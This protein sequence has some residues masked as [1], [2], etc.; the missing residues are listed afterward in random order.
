MLLVP[1]QLRRSGMGVP[2]SHNT[3]ARTA[4]ATVKRRPPTSAGGMLSSAMRMARY[5]VPHTTQTDI[6]AR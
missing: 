6:Q 2:R 3:S 1:R 5:V 4:P